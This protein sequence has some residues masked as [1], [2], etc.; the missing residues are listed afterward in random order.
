MRLVVFSH[1]VCWPSAASAV[2]FATDGGFVFQMQALASVFDALT[3]V[4]PVTTARPEGEVLFASS[5]I[6]VVALPMLK[7][8]GWRRKCWLPFW[9]LRSLPLLLRMMNRADAVHAPIPGDVGTIG[10]LLAHLLR[11]PL[12]VRHCGNWHQPRTLAE[13][14]WKWYMESFAGGKRIFFATGGNSAPPS[15]K[16]KNIEWIFSTSLSHAQ[17]QANKVRAQVG[18]KSIIRLIIVCRQDER[19]GVGVV[20]RALALLPLENFILDVVGD[21]PALGQFKAL[22]YDLGVGHRV[23]FHGKL[24]QQ[25][26]VAAMKQ[27]D[28]FCYPTSASEGFPKVVLEAMSCGL[29]V[30]ATPVSVLKDM[31]AEGKAGML[32]PAPSAS[33]LA[34]AVSSLAAD[35]IKLRSCS[36][37]AMA[38]VAGYSLENWAQLIKLKADAA[39]GLQP[40]TSTMLTAVGGN[41]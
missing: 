15:L 11:K 26:V 23:N 24:N 16:N 9:L 5:N 32:I 12:L 4:V 18:N 2:G 20:I 29:P 17:L 41:A 39:W 25:G 14:F 8:R 37:H 33:V 36:E 7:G 13:K 38:L 22:A 28:I 3:I 1:K 35:T 31:L 34:T 19:K 30:I 27:A 40:H 6:E 21:G 10:M